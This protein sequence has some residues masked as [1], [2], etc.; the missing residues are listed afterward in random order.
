[1][2]AMFVTLALVF[3]QTP[4]LVVTV[5]HDGA[6][7]AG[8]SLT[9]TTVKVETDAQGKANVTV[10]ATGCTLIVTRE[11]LTPFSQPVTTAT[12]PLI[13]DLEET[14]EVEEEITVSATRTGRLA[15]S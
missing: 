9:C 11:G 12:P 13:I 3:F 10:P 5:R 2:R 8:A 15:S 6:P 4:S 7:V 1:M 14:V